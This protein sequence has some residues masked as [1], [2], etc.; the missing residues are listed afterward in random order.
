[1][2][3]D[4]D[5]ARFAR[6]IDAATAYR[7]AERPAPAPPVALR[8]R[9]IAVT[10]VDRL[11]ADP[12]AFYARAML[13]LSSWDPVDAEPSPA[14]RG[15]LIHSVLEEWMVEDRCAP[16]RLDARVEAML[17]DSATHPLMRTLWAPRLAEAIGWIGAEMT[18]NIADG[19]T[20]L[21]AEAAGR[22][23]IA[24]VIL[25]GKADRIDRLADGRLA[26][27][28]YKT[29]KAPSPGEVTAGYAMQLGLLGLIAERGGFEGVTGTPGAFEYW[30]LA[31]GPKG[32]LGHV[33]SPVAP[34]RPDRIDPDDFTRQAAR[35]FA[36]AAATWL[37]GS[38]AFTAKLHPER[39]PYG[40][41]DQLMRL[42]EWY[43]RGDGRT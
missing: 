7:P 20:P 9:S 37:T 17:A 6:L 1:V 34:G 16:D 25:R 43:G 30:S 26:I 24:G 32:S 23:Q 40:D 13:R 5:K 3:R 4:G 8:P 11:K 31:R 10:E 38:E 39:A 29:G 19:R 14:W 35:M 27:V 36:D 33:S 22:I 2:R 42:E 12:F 28:D 18:R 15:T 41:Y 21:V